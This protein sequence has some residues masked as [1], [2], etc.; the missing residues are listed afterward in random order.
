MI[1]VSTFFVKLIFIFSDQG[2]SLLWSWCSLPCCICSAQAFQSLKKIVQVMV[3]LFVV[4]WC[5]TP[6][7]TIFQ[8]Y[9]GCQFYWWRKPEYPEKTTNQPQVT[10]KLSHNVV[11]LTLI[12]IRTYNISS[13][14]HWS[15]CIG[16][17]KSNYHTITATMAI[18]D[19]K[20]LNR[21]KT[22]IITRILHI[23]FMN[24]FTNINK[25]NS[26]LKSLKIKKS[27]T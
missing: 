25:V 26:R 1:H 18:T 22:T 8:L 23:Y 13:D 12:K 24:Q 27:M 15:V 3:S 19:G 4:W 14:R 20:I 2:K 17:C 5:L 7:W 6:L 11:H 16:S 10:D 21:I 9:C